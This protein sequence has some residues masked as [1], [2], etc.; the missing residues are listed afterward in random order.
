MTENDTSLKDIWRQTKRPVIFRQG[1]GH[2]L[3]LKLPYR[4]DNKDWIRNGRRNI[5]NWNAHYKCWEIPMAW[6]EKAIRAAFDRFEGIYVIQPLRKQQKCA[7]ACWNAEGIECE[8]SC[9]GGNHGTG[10]PLGRWYV[11]SETCAVSWG[12]RDYIASLMKPK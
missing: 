11:V 7:P 2:P 5:P 1:L 12:Q 6:F 8:C 10:H 9:M 4:A 3:L